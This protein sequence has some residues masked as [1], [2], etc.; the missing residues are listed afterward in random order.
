MPSGENMRKFDYAVAAAGMFIKHLH[1]EDFDRGMIA[2]FGNTFRV[3][4]GFTGE[5]EQLHLT[6]ARIHREFYRNFDAHNGGEKTRLY[7]SIVDMIN[8]FRNSGKRDRPWI[9]TVVTDG[10]DEPPSVTE[11]SGQPEKT[12]YYIATH[13]NHESSNYIFVVGVGEDID[14]VALT[15]L[16]D[17]GRFPAMTIEAFPL[18]EKQFLRI[19][20]E[21]S[22][23]VVG[24]RPAGESWEEVGRI[25]RLALTPIDY[26]FLIDRSGTMHDFETTVR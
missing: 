16:A 3:E 7:T 21:V 23:Q 20:V 11:Y 1:T 26:A 9:L 13:Y 19:A 18:L 8:E 15:K 24:V 25:R 6:L 5:E 14:R 10:R 12:G 17:V 22:S 4:Q 2:T